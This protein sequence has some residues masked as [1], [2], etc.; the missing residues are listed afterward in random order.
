MKKIILIVSFLLF[1]ISNNLAQTVFSSQNASAS[2][3]LVVPLSI[4]ATIG[5]LD[6]GSILLSNSTIKVDIE[7]REGKLFIVSGHPTREVTFTFDDV[8][9]DNT[10]W[11]ASNGGLVDY[12]TFSPSVELESGG[13]IKSGKSKNLILDGSIGKLNV[14]VGGNIKISSRQEVGD[15]I[16]K[17]TLNVNY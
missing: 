6:F 8:T 3:Y 1:L 17:F 4:T 15:Y 2:A 11:A 10:N 13:K 7:P 5:D 9:M 14:W 12:L 16:G